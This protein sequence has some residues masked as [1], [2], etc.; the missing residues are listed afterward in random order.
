MSTIVEE[1]GVRDGNVASVC[2]YSVR[3]RCDLVY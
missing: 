3:G 2:V 1:E